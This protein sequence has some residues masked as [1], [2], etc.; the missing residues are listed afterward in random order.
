MH[1]CT[2]ACKCTMGGCDTETETPA[3]EAHMMM[4]ID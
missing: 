2:S 4:E 3:T 1:A